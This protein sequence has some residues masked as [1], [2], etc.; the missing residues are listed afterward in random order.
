M[1]RF[2]FAR[3]ASACPR[4][5]VCALALSL[6]LAAEAT[7]SAPAS[8]LAAETR[9]AVW[10]TI[11]SALGRQGI[12][13]GQPPRMEDLDMPPALPARAGQKL[14]VSSACWDEGPRRAQFRLQCAAP[15]GCLP[16]LVY[17]RA[18]DLPE[19]QFQSC[20]AEA[21]HIASAT[22]P[23][24]PPAAFRPGDQ[25]RA[26]FLGEGLRM[27]ASVTC[28]DRGGTGD[29]IRVRTVD[30]RILRARISGPT[31]L[32]VLPRYQR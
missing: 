13:T 12:A 27:T 32:E 10:Q 26:V 31:L 24:A 30:G 1:T 19:A 28:L 25:A 4:T 6:S 16:F 20:R 7:D 5:A 23:A 3:I 8:K 2:H 18:S 22:A 11:V 17:W 21:P 14:Q 9:P 29:V 15:D